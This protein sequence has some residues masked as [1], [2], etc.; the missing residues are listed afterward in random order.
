MLIECHTVGP[1]FITY[2][3]GYRVISVKGNQVEVNSTTYKKTKM[4]HV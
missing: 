3:G 4:V 1:F 2:I